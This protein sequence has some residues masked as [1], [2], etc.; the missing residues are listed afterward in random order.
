MEK[1]LTLCAP[2]MYGAL[3]AECIQSPGVIKSQQACTFPCTSC[4]ANKHHVYTQPCKDTMVQT[5][6]HISPQKRRPKVWVEWVRQQMKPVQV[7][8][9]IEHF[10]RPSLTTANT[11]GNNTEQH[12]IRAPAGRHTQG[13]I[14]RPALHPGFLAWL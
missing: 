3:S 4:Q 9:L 5:G 8:R 6:M 12:C 14:S 1:I 7:N 13:W 11:C 10:W 2:Q